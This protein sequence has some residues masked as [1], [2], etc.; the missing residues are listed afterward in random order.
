MMGCIRV[1]D[2]HVIE[3]DASELV[4]LRNPA[5][6]VQEQ[7]VTKLHDVRLVHAGDFLQG[8][9]QG[10]NIGWKPRYCTLRRES[11]QSV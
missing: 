11:S 5:E 7:T 10:M 8:A 1:V 6:G 2:D 4:L 9:R 3:L